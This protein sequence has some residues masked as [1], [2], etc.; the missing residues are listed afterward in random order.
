MIFVVVVV[1]VFFFSSRRRHTR[2]ALVTGVQ[3]CALPI[4]R[5]GSAFAQCRLDLFENGLEVIDRDS[6]VV[7]ADPGVRFVQPV[8]ALFLAGYVGALN[9]LQQV[10]ES[11]LQDVLQLLDGV[12]GMHW[13][14]AP[15]IR[16]LES[17]AV[18]LRWY[19]SRA[20]TLGSGRSIAR[21]E[22]SAA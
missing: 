3:T 17:D 13:H 20:G 21:R 19:R 15:P 7:G 9:C 8:H 14:G 11:F 2:C 10:V 18:S 6:H 22:G 5:A 1:M 12:L 16:R 4:L